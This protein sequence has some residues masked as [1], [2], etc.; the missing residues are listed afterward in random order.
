MKVGKKSE[1]SSFKS[2][3]GIAAMNIVAINPTVEELG[4]VL[5]REIQKVPQYLGK[6]E[7]DTPQVS[8]SFWT[9]TD[10]TSE[11]NNGI[12]L[13]TPFM[14]TL[15]DKERV[16]KSGK[17]QIID[18]YGRSAWATPEEIAA[19]SIPQYSNG[20]ANI[21]EGYHTAMPGEETLLSFL[22]AWLNIPD[23]RVYNSNTKKWED[24]SRVSPEDCEMSLDYQ[25]LFKGDFSELKVLVEEVKEYAVK[26][27]V[28]IRT[29]D[30]GYKRENVYTGMFLKNS[31][32]KYDNLM[33]GIIDSQAAGSYSTTE[34]EGTPL[35]EYNPQPTDFTSSSET[36]DSDKVD[37]WK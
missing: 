34:F 3:I 22:K 12:D 32:R 19:G 5:E 25:K 21:S 30:K 4:K 9:R 18:K 35:H 15:S 27:A 8:L 33:Q 36:S 14:I 2:Y 11:V 6:D 29:D 20:P 31:A 24:N 37:P 26:V 13:V 23:I 17:K 1:E 28:G 16:S 7:N 10:K